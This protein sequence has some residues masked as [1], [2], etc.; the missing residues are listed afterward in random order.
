[1]PKYKYISFT[2]LH[3][4]GY[5]QILGKLHELNL[6][7]AQLR[8]RLVIE[9]SKFGHRTKTASESGGVDWKALSHA[10]RVI[11]QFNELST[12]QFIKFPL[13][14]ADKLITIKRCTDTEALTP[15]LD[16]LHIK[17]AQAEKAIDDSK[18]PDSV[19]LEFVNTI[20]L[21]HYNLI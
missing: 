4:I 5:I 18:L 20:T 16:D 19:N 2:N 12:T 15:I 9:L 13:S 21:I 10:Y 1:M 6:T 8:Q 17:L 11:E 7:V 14:C 3:G